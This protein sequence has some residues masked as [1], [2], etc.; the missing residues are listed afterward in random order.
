MNRVTARELRQNI[1]EAL[2]QMP[3]ELVLDGVVV[4]V[5]SNPHDGNQA[6]KASHDGNQANELRFSKG[7]QARGG[8]SNVAQ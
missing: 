5:V 4:A 8:L 1:T 6:S 2:K 7:R 3:F